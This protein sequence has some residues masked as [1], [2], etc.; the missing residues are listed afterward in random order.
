[1]QPTSNRLQSHMFSSVAVQET[2]GYI[3][4][5]V[6]YFKQYTDW[7]KS[8]VSIQPVFMFYSVDVSFLRLWVNNFQ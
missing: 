8:S 6:G 2:K 3:L 7:V 4:S 1:M 5:L